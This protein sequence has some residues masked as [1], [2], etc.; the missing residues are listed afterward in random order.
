MKL[1]GLAKIQLTF[2]ASLS[3]ASVVDVIGFTWANL[4]TDANGTVKKSLVVA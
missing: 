1:D 2:A 4:A 3:A